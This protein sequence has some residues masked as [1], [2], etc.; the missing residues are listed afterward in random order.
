MDVGE[1]HHETEGEPGEGEGRSLWEEKLTIQ[2]PDKCISQLMVLDVEFQSDG[3][4]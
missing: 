4:Q 3:H 1:R 2:I